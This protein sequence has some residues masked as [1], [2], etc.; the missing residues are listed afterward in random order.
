MKK[1]L[2]RIILACLVLT[3]G[4]I[5]IAELDKRYFESLNVDEIF[6]HDDCLYFM[7]SEY[8]AMTIC[9]AENLAKLEQKAGY[10]AYLIETKARQQK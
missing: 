6:A 10:L 1:Y 7:T 2:I 9:G 3:F 5:A 4:S 8:Q